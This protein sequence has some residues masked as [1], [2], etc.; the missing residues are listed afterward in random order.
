MKV[1]VIMA[2]RNKNDML[3]NTLYSLAK[4]KTSFPYEVC[5][6]DDHSDIDPESIIRQ[7]IPDVKYKRLEKQVGFM[8]SQGLC[9]D[10]VSNDVNIIVIQSDD[11]IYTSDDS[12]EKLVAPVES[13]VIALAEV[14]DI[15]IPENLFNS[16]DNE[17][18]K[19]L[20]DWQSYIKRGPQK[21]DDRVYRNVWTKYSGKGHPSWLFFLG[22][23]RKEDLELLDF[24]TNNCDAVISP[25]MKKLGFKAKYP[26]VK[27]IHQNHPKSLY[28]CPIEDTCT[29]YCGR[30]N[31]KRK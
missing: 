9:L 2:T 4:Q 14:V 18:N 17:V 30:K 12:L 13:K 7:F 6:I 10:L 23:I 20:N 16:F 19:I 11:I 26:A 28:P 5:V 8:F 31:K 3:P 22:A 24:K 15:P 29:Y 25:K 1:S 27:G 21:I